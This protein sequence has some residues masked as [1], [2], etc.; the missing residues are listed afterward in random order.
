MFFLLIRYFL[1]SFIHQFN[2][3][4]I[5]EATNALDLILALCFP[6]GPAPSSDSLPPLP[7]FSFFLFLPLSSPPSFFFLPPPPFPFFSAFSFFGFPF[8]SFFFF[9]PSPPS[10]PPPPPPSSPVSGPESEMS[11]P[12]LFFAPLE[13]L[14]ALIVSRISSNFR[15]FS[16][17]SK[18]CFRL[19]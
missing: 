13:P 7:P 15:I 4:Y 3:S 18:Y 5:P 19:S 2:Y 12:F 6:L 11:P 10:P 1:K 16:V 14:G 9:F 8:F 17:F